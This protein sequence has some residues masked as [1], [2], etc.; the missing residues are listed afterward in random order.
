MADKLTNMPMR[1]PDDLTLRFATEADA[2]A[3]GAFNS[4]H[5]DD[6]K[7][8][9]VVGRSVQ[10]L[11]EGRHP[12]IS[13]ADFTVV[14]HAPT[15]R[16]VSSMCLL[17]QTWTYAG[18]PFA[19]GQPEFVATAKE[20]R[21]RGLVR[22]QFD[23]IHALSA[24]RGELM[25]GITGIPWYYSQ[26]GYD[27]ALRLG[28]A[29]PIHRIHLREAVKEPSCKLR[30]LAPDDESFVRALH[31]QGAGRQPFGVERSDELWRYEFACGR[32][33]GFAASEWHIIETPVGER[34]GYLAHSAWLEWPWLNVTQLELSPEA[35]YLN[36]M[37]SLLRDLIVHAQDM[38]ETDL[39]PVKDVEGVHL[40]LGE[41]HP[42]YAGVTAK[43]TREEGAYAWYVRVPDLVAFLRHVRAGLERNLIDS[44]AQGY[45]GELGISF[46]RGGVR[47]TLA[48]GTITGIEEWNSEDARIRFPREQFT[49]LLCG[50][51]RCAELSEMFADVSTP[52]PEAVV[53]DALFPPF[54]GSVWQAI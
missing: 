11:V 23:V 32:E 42:A 46:Y 20:Y 36:V 37:P 43:K 33:R 30:P 47:I 35:C 34:L 53:L 29:R 27:M 5:H 22:Q 2:E 41:Q 51:R 26:F 9:T 15:G 38:V 17:S 40:G 50:R 49:H 3:L 45:T 24:A 18:V 21:R 7:E 6:N 48:R 13:A 1:L 12:G 52:H 8:Y 14:E 39:H 28:G 54:T 31:V 16:I 44:P 4:E 25:Q 10:G 19:F